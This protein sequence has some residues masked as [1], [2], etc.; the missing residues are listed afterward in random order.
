MWRASPWPPRRSGYCGALRWYRDAPLFGGAKRFGWGHD[1][2]LPHATAAFGRRAVV[3]RPG[4]DDRRR[5]LDGRRAALREALAFDSGFGGSTTGLAELLDS[6][7]FVL[8]GFIAGLSM[9]MTSTNRILVHGLPARF[10]ANWRP[11]PNMAAL[12]LPIWILVLLAF[13]TAA[14]LLGG[15]AH[16]VA[17]NVMIMLAVSFCVAGLAVRHVLARR[18]ARPVIP[19]VTPYVLAGAFGWPL[20]LVALLGCSINRSGCD[21]ASLSPGSVEDFDD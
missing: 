3:R 14:M 6:V 7:A 21:G 19:L 13:A 5:C 11:S 1:A 15:T 8:P 2:D 10:G 9:A 18:P 20:L 17:I 12:S 4:F 16:F